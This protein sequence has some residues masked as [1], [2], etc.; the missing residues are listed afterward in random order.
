MADAQRIVIRKVEGGGFQVAPD[1]LVAAR[2]D[3]AVTRPTLREA[4]RFAT[5]LKAVKGWPIVDLSS[6]ATS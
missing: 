3:R 1:P 5:S 4:Q 6:G 2:L